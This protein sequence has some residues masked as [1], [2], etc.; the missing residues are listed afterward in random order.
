[1]TGLKK[2]T[3]LRLVS[4]DMK[5]LTNKY[6]ILLYRIILSVVFIFAGL[7]KI[8]SPDVFAESI[9]NYKLFPNFSINIIAITV[10][11]IELITGLFLLFG[12]TIKETLKI[13]NSMMLFFI[14][15][16][17]FALV[18]GLDIECGCFGTHNAQKVGF[19]KL[20]ENTILLSFG[21]LLYKCKPLIIVITEQKE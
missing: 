20:F 18:R 17:L 13:I 3:L 15:I 14:I 2:A 6:S 7:E 19:I 1:M 10:P 4:S 9:S 16:I 12:I 11:W 5:I 8:I 21:I